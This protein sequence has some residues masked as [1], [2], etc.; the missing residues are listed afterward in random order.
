MQDADLLPTSPLF[1]FEGAKP[2]RSSDIDGPLV[3]RLRRRPLTPQTWV[4]FPH[5]SPKIKGFSGVKPVGDIVGVNDDEG[6]PVPIP[7][8]AVKL[9]CADNTCLVTDWKDRS[10]P[11]QTLWS[12]RSKRFLLPP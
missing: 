4:R 9:T 7:N 1:G 8:T 5:G 3:K 2:V 11:T 10:A 6:P 12:P